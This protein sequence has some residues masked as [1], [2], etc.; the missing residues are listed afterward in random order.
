MV[1]KCF[2]IKQRVL[3]LKELEWVMEVGHGILFSRASRT[4]RWKSEKGCLVV[5]YIQTSQPVCRLCVILDTSY[6]SKPTQRLHT[7]PTFFT[8]RKC[9]S[10]DSNSSLPVSKSCVLEPLHGAV[11]SKDN[12]RPFHFLWKAVNKLCLQ[13]DF[14]APCCCVHQNG[15]VTDTGSRS[16]G[17]I[18]SVSRI[19]CV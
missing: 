3:N 2:L 7:L 5:E 19:V 1:G 12:F 16:L 17:T 8:A 4:E 9:W 15:H 10:Q 14:S 11:S 13:I 18:G 6:E